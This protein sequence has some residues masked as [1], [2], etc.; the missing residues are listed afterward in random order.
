MSNTRPF[1]KAHQLMLVQATISSVCTNPAPWA[2]DRT[3]VLPSIVGPRPL[4]P[5]QPRPHALFQDSSPEPPGARA[6][7]HLCT[8]PLPAGNSHHRRPP[9]LVASEAR[10]VRL[11]DYQTTAFL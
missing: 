3:G 9:P 1:K 4:L 10:S 7:V 8:P 2:Q 6:T 5:I 11:P